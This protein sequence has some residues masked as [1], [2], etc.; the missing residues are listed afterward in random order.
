MDAKVAQKILRKFTPSSYAHAS[1]SQD[2]IAGGP[3]VLRG[4]F[5]FAAASTPTF[6]IVNG[7]STG[8]ANNIANTFTP[9]VGFHELPDVECSALS[10]AIG[11]D[12]DY[13]VFYKPGN[14]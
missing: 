2:N 14:G 4:Y 11:G 6:K 5:I 1:T 13:T 7:A 10:I 3:C 9:T 8:V 12:V